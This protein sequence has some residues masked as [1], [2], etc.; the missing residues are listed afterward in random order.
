MNIV[1]SQNNEKVFFAD[2][3]VLVEG[4]SDRIFFEAVFDELGRRDLKHAVVEVVSV[5]GK[6]L[7]QSYI[8]LL[9]AFEISHSLIADQDY[10]EQAGSPEIR[11]LFA[12]N[13]TEIGSDV[14]KNPRSLD[15]AALVNTIEEAFS[16]GNWGPAKEV[17]EYIKS[18]RIS[19][20]IDL[21][22]DEIKL[23][24][25]FILDQRGNGVCILSRGALEAYLPEGFRSK[26]IGHLIE[27]VRRSDFW[28]L[29]GEDEKS[30]LQKVSESILSPFLSANLALVE[31][32]PVQEI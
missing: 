20:R 11:S 16:S 13:S 17:W 10:I 22:E 7:F 15:G 14:L 12:S 2:H 1:N 30:E 9:T 29:I 28:E 6:G 4:L 23:L 21:T 24:D 25:A 18:R 32:H 5:G 3:V 8:K 27:F 19:L 31:N 26:D